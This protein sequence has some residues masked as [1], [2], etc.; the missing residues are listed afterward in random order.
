MLHDDFLGLSATLQQ[1]KDYCC[2]GEMEEEEILA[3]FASLSYMQSN[4]DGIKIK[5]I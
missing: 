5:Y 3:M 1:V 2:G 4:K